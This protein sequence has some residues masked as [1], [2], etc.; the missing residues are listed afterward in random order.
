MN[1][2]S[3]DTKYY[4]IIGF[5]PRGIGE[6]EPHAVCNPDLPTS[7]S[8]DLRMATEGILGSSD[9]ALGRLW[10]MTHAWGR[11]C[12]TTMDTDGGPDIKEYIATAFVARDMLEIVERHAAYVADKIARMSPKTE[13]RHQPV[14]ALVKPSEA[15][16]DY[17]GFSYGTFLGST[18]ASMY[19]DRVGRVV[20]DGVVSSWDYNHSLGNGSLTDNQ[21]AFKSFYTYCVSAGPDLCPLATASS[22]AADVEDRVQ[23]IVKSLYHNP[24]SLNV[25]IGPEILTYSDVKALLF[26]G[27]YAP[28]GS[29]PQIAELLSEIEVGHGEIID[30]ISSSFHFTHV[31]SCSANGSDSPANYANYVPTFAVLCSDGDDQTNVNIDEFAEYWELL[32]SLSPTAGAIW[33]MLKM[34]CTSWNIKASYK[35]EGPFGGK[36]SNP[37]LFVSNTADPVTPLRS[38]RLMQSYFEGSGLLTL[39]TAG[40]CSLTEPTS[41]TLKHIKSYYQTGA[42]PPPNTLCVPPPSPWSLNS[43]DPESPF[44]DPSLE[45]MQIERTMSLDTCMQE[46]DDVNDMR[47]LMAGN[48]V[49]SDVLSMDYFGL[50]KLAAGGMHLMDSVRRG[51]AYKATLSGNRHKLRPLVG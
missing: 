36:T 1:E 31:Y 48:N 21:K 25:S 28:Q 17:W 8:W 14:P 3:D 2:K 37:I 20:L 7:W 9:A 6:T 18:F 19:P 11:D 44:Y 15:K 16:L 23:R 50:G 33:S 4:D 26:S 29:W 51:A 22:T 40:H 32:E 5:D 35:F 38:G 10:V 42:L 49:A 27:T 41:C 43:T 12:K 45:G 24:L 46:C 34:R 47:L 39:D 13:G 30:M